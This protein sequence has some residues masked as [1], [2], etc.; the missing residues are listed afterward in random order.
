MHAVLALQRQSS[1]RLV[2]PWF[3]TVRCWR[4]YERGR[5]LLLNGDIRCLVVAL[6]TPSYHIGIVYDIHS[7]VA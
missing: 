3:A 4:P 1:L 2:S 6:F 5:L 7:L